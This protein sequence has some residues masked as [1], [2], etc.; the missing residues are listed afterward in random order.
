VYISE[1]TEVA[2]QVIRTLDVVGEKWSLLI[3][4][5]LLRGSTRFS[6]F[7]TSLGVP[8]DVLT[9]RLGTLVDRGIVEK[10]PYRE[11]GARERF[12]YHLTPAGEGLRVVLAALIQ[13]G[14]E[15]DPAPTGRGSLLV[16]A[17]TREPVSLGYFGDDG[18]RVAEIAIAPG[19]RVAD[20]W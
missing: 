16:D 3:V 6:E 20:P 1:G 10:R 12:S 14:D 13:W 17:D 9:A 19:P 8:T 15:F 18:R 5:D 7:R 2:C 4:R 11:E